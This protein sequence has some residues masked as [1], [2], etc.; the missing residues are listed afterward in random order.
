MAKVSISNRTKSPELIPEDS[1]QWN[2]L[3]DT[4][5]E[6]SYKQY[7]KEHEIVVSFVE[8]EEIQELNR[9]YR[10]KNEATDVLSFNAIGNLCSDL[11]KFE[12]L[13]NVGELEP[14]DCALGDIVICVPLAQAQAAERNCELKQE[15]V[16]LF[17][18]GLLHLLGY[19]H[20]LREEAEQMF[21][22]QNTVLEKHG[23]L[24]RISC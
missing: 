24:V 19:D 7:F 1:I 22:L 18:H 17:V 10:Y 8:A 12:D 14:E 9:L 20:V 4:V 23:Y 16:M 2:L 6:D 15:I 21:G 5:L 13:A 3:A 11:E